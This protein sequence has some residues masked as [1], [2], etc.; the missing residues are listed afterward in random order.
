MKKSG[1]RCQIASL[2]QTSLRPP[3]ANPQPHGKRHGDRLTTDK[4]SRRAHHGADDRSG[5]GAGDQ[6]GQKGPGQREVGRVVVEQQ[7]GNDG[8]AQGDAET[9]REDQPFSPGAL[10]GQENAAELAK[11][12]QHCRQRGGNRQL[13]HQR[14]QQIL[15]GRQE[16]GFV[17]HG[18]D[19]KRC[20]T[21]ATGPTSV[22]PSSAPTCYY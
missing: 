17:G 1:E 3:P 18:V 15:R 12:H 10:F 22:K 16:S 21:I 11:P 4:Q 8:P 2:G 20:F 5:I 19:T 6:P 7:T 14:C 13:H 9:D